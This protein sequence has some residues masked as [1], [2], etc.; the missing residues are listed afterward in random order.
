VS[1]KILLVEDVP[2]NRRL[3]IRALSRSG[4]D[5]SVDEAASQ[6]EAISLASQQEYDW[7]ILDEDLAP[8]KGAEVFPHLRVPLDRVLGISGDNPQSYLSVHFPKPDLI[9]AVVHILDH[10]PPR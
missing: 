7:V 2:A 8:G 5:V 4:I 6:E 10:L 1:L 3:F 9:K